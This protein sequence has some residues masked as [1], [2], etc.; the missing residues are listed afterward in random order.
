MSIIIDDPTP[1]LTKLNGSVGR[2]Q[3]PNNPFTLRYLQTSVSASIPG[4]HQHKLLE[5]IK[6]IRDR[7]DISNIRTVNDILQRDVDDSRVARDI[8]PYLLST[9]NKPV[10]FPSIV[11]V[12]FPK[13]N[14]TRNRN[15]YPLKEEVQNHVNYEDFW[16]YRDLLDSTG[17]K[18]GLGELS[19]NLFRT[20]PLAIDGQHRTAAF[21]WLSEIDNNGSRIYDNFYS[22]LTKPENFDSD[23]PVTIL[24]FEH[25]DNNDTKRIN[26][27]DISRDIFIDIN[28]SS[29]QISKSRHI[30]MNN[31]SPSEFVTRR[32]YEL[33]ASKGYKANDELN[34]M[35]SGFDYPYNV[36]NNIAWSHYTMFVPEIISYSFGWLLFAKRHFFTNL[37]NDKVN[38]PKKHSGSDFFELIVGEGNLGLYISKTVDIEEQVSQ[39]I[40][41]ERERDL[42]IKL[43]QNF[44]PN[45]YSHLNSNGLY[46][47]VFETITEISEN[48][49]DPQR[50]PYSASAS[51]DAWNHMYLGA[52]GLFYIVNN[53][54]NP[55]ATDYKQASRD[56]ESEFISILGRKLDLD[57]KETAKIL[58]SIQSVAYLVG[59]LA[60][61]NYFTDRYD[62]FARAAGV[63]ADLN[64]KIDWDIYL[65]AIDFMKTDYIKNV[66]PKT[67][68]AYRNI[69]LRVAHHFDD[70]VYADP[71]N[72]C[73]ERNLEKFYLAD[74]I[75][76]Y[77]KEKQYTNSQLKK[78]IDTAQFNLI[79][80]DTYEFMIESSERKTKERMLDIFG[81][82]VY[83]SN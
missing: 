32:F 20:N 59:Y 37:S 3:L 44:L 77:G 82:D 31:N 28:Q 58:K 24:W 41:P 10:F 19:L 12:L 50:I 22:K 43:S 54:S 33:L 71:A 79:D 48:F 39:I 16:T 46:K 40:N 11:V 70:S 38:E 55:G 30:L 76:D 25:A 72:E 83:I 29:Q 53:S 47:A 26:I 66:D 63:T 81:E 13:E 27:K 64:E 17:N 67:W 23:L 21:R 74:F 8:I 15:Y 9:R 34:L 69:Y 60:A 73:I 1:Q 68:P 6:P 75:K 61:L 42:L 4:S 36:S 65:K 45:I 80:L 7:L 2:F 5:E 56:I 57:L 78:D 62:S 52:E 35:Y 51:R 49:E 14:F 18:T